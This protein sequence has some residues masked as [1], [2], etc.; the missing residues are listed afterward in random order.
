MLPYGTW[1]NQIE[2]TGVPYGIACESTDSA[3]HR[4]RSAGK[5]NYLFTDAQSKLN[6]RQYPIRFQVPKNPVQT[7]R[8]SR[9]HRPNC[10][11]NTEPHPNQTG[12][13]IASPC[14][15]SIA[16]KNWN[17]ISEENNIQKIEV[18][19]NAPTHTCR[20]TKFFLQLGRQLDGYYTVDGILYYWNVKSG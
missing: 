8:S 10:K 18:S 4:R 3:R 17:G 12:M 9:Y 20:T 5:K 1:D 2:L 11:F 13:L 14:M 16:I 15:I 7:Q 19:S 6:R